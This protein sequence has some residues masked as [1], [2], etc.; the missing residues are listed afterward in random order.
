M[1]I[2]SNSNNNSSSNLFGDVVYKSI[3]NQKN[4]VNRTQTVKRYTPQQQQ[5]KKLTRANIKFLQ[6]LGLRVKKH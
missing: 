5:T 3:Y 4:I 1:L 2:Y 6:N